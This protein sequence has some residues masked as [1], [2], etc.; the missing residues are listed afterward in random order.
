MQA[1]QK[2]QL[3]QQEI[4]SVL[5]SETMQAMLLMCCV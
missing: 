2:Y 1:M 3:F 4:R 5:S